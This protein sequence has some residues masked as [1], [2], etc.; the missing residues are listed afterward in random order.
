MTGQIIRN[1]IIPF[2]FSR[3]PDFVLDKLTQTD[4]FIP[5]YHMVSDSEH[6]HVKHL[7]SYKNI[8]QFTH[9]LD[10]L[11]RRYS[12]VSLFEFLDF[13]KTGKSL[14]R[15]P[16][17][18]TFDDGF[19]EINDTIAPILVKKGFPALFFVN[20]AFVDNKDLC[21]Q[22]KVSILIEHLEEAGSIELGEKLGQI[23]SDNKIKF[24]DIKAGLLSMTY[25]DKGIIDE[26]AEV[27]EVDFDGYLLKNRPY[28]TS[29]EIK[30]LIEDG[31]AI[32]AHSMDHPLYALLTLEDQLDQ[33]IES[34]RL[35]REM[36]SL[37]YGA[38]AFPNSDYGVSQD[39]FAELDK[40]GLVD[41]SFGNRGMTNNMLSKTFQRLSMEKPLISAERIIALQLARRGWKLLKGTNKMVRKL[42]D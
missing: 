11:M 3:I 38:F 41:V 15:K 27:M 20:S 22:H 30:S 13:I 8:R 37:T 28:L 17:L 33:T 42:G 14:P 9:D 16:L 18:L 34:T 12:P 21:Y 6:L 40:S 26:V 24:S 10:F 1:T 7:Y 23:L 32:G 25:L 39:F 35:I 29:D 5:Y 2:L 36:F 19:R 31:F 4:I